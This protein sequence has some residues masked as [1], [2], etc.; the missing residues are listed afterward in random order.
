MS[1]FA[2]SWTIVCLFKCSLYILYSLGHFAVN[3]LM[4]T[5]ANIETLDK[6][7]EALAAENGF[8][9]DE[10]SIAILQQY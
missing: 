7:I 8:L 10:Q 3:L 1:T 5:A 9:I 6:K 2:I 4:F